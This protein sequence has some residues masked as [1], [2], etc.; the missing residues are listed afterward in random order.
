[1]ANH[2]ETYCQVHNLKKEGAD[3]LRKLFELPKNEAG[4]I[5]EYEVGSLQLAERMYNVSDEEVTREFCIERFG[6]K[7]L[8]VDVDY[9]DDEDAAF[10]I[11]SAWAVPS[12]FI[13]ELVHRLNLL[14][15]SQDVFIAGTYTDEGYDPCG[16]YVYGFQYYD[17]EDLFGNDC[18][19]EV[20]TELMWDDDDYNE[21]VYERLAEHRE[22]M[23]SLYYQVKQELA[24]ESND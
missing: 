10:N 14:Q 7:W 2:M 15:K 12:E 8:T 5:T 24:E 9:I 13:P 20:D 23:I 19:E 1:M 21:Q 16:A 4:Q 6:A 11:T 22:H 18:E 3:Y 17:I